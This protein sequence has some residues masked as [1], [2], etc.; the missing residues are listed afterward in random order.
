VTFRRF[1]DRLVFHILDQGKGFDWQ[2][3]LEMSPERAFD[4]HGRGIAMA[5]MLSFAN[6]SYLRGG[7]EA[8]CTVRSFDDTLP[9]L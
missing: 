1:P 3:F 7:R 2:S 8:I 4:V 5:K 6:L 9:R